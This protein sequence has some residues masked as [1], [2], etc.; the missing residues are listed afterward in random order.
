M[1]MLTY[2]NLSLI[3]LIGG[4]KHDYA[5]IDEFC[6]KYKEPLKKALV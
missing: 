4:L 3:W 1:A 6:R 5:T 2:Y